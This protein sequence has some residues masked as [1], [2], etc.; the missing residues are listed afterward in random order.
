MPS[1]GP[2]FLSKYK[3]TVQQGNSNLGK[4]L[5]WESHYHATLGFDSLVDHIAN[6]KTKRKEKVNVTFVF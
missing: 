2:L 3:M 6:K 5:D 1:R 4:A